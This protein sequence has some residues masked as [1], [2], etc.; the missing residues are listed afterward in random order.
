MLLAIV[1]PPA[2]TAKQDSP[3]SAPTQ[4]EGKYMKVTAER[5]NLKPEKVRFNVS[6][7]YLIPSG[8][9]MFE[10]KAIH[11]DSVELTS[12]ELSDW[13]TDDKVIF[14]KIAPKFNVSVVKVEELTIRNDDF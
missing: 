14:D 10:F 5:Y 13:G 7:G 9:D 2:V 3:F 1:N 4:V 8:I 6:F 12:A 11:R